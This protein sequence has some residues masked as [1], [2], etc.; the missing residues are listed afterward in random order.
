ML[1]TDE[2]R[3]KLHISDT[4]WQV[5]EQGDPTGLVRAVVQEIDYD[6]TTGAVSLKLRISGIT[7]ED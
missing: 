5:F 6:G 1:S 7:N 4:D 2:T 3:Q